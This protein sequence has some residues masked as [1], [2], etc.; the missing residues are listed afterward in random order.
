MRIRPIIS[1]VLVAFALMGGCVDDNPGFFIL[2]AAVPDTQCTFDESSP[3]LT[4]GTF[5]VGNPYA[6]YAMYPIYQSWLRTRYSG[7]PPRVDA[8]GIQIET[9]N[10][11]LT[12]ASGAPLPISQPNFSVTS[13]GFVPTALDTT[14]GT[15]PGYIDLIPS[16]AAD[17]IRDLHLASPPD[18]SGNATTFDLV[19]H[20]TVLGR[21]VGG[22]SIQTQEW[23]WPI[24]ICDGCYRCAGE[25]PEV[26]CHPGQDGEG[27]FV[28]ADCPP[29]I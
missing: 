20:V 17:E 21:T 3:A 13:T 5:D 14:A 6:H 25:V 22:Q 27:W 11:R 12:D 1:L 19:A 28:N 18:A 16:I 7:S 15:G 29:A 9:A 4:T 24:T 8:N 23:S 26:S 2:N 10:V